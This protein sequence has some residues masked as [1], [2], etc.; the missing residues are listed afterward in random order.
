MLSPED[1]PISATEPHIIAISKA[2]GPATQTDDSDTDIFLVLTE[3]IVKCYQRHAPPCIL[4]IDRQTQT[5]TA[6]KALNKL[7]VVL[8]Y[9][10][11]PGEGQWNHLRSIGGRL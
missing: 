6:D 8:T 5:E 1:R 10:R 7:N 2:K 11:Y 4:G 9:S 3:V